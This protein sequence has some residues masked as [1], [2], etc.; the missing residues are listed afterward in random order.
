[1][2]ACSFQEKTLRDSKPAL[3]NSYNRMLGGIEGR[4]IGFEEFIDGK[5]R[6][7]MK[8]SFVNFH[9]YHEIQAPVNQ[10][11]VLL[12]MSW[13]VADQ[14]AFFSKDI[15]RSGQHGFNGLGVTVVSDKL[16]GDND[17]QRKSERNLRHLL[18]PEHEDVPIVLTRSP[19]S[20]T[21]SGDL[22]VDNLAGWLTK[23]MTDPAGDYAAFARNLMSTGVWRGWHQLLPS[24]TELKA[25]PAEARLTA[26][27][28]AEPSA[29]ADQHGSGA[30]E[31]RM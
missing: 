13:F 9:G 21:F 22:L 2:S 7:Q 28:S 14:F 29:A 27:A 1:V 10:M 26:A 11:L 4:R 16:S 25:A 23:A 31:S 12:L 5:G 19:T 18:D 3:L 6:R 15:V 8:H 30:G 24:T 17:F 20:D